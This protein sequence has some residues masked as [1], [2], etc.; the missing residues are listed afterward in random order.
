MSFV[1]IIFSLCRIRRILLFQFGDVYVML[2]HEIKCADW[3]AQVI[4]SYAQTKLILGFYKR[5][6]R[7][8]SLDG[9]VENRFSVGDG[10]VSRF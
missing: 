10:S 7:Y 1:L 5:V 3:L 8:P 2:T 9:Q 4:F 6:D